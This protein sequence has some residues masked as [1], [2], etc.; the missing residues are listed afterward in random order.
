[1]K[2][3]THIFLVIILA[4][5]MITVGQV[6][7]FSFL[8]FDF[9]AN[10]TW[11]LNQNMYG[12][13]ELNYNLKFGFSGGASYKYFANKFGYSVGLG[14]GSF[15]QRYSGNMV[16]AD[17]KLRINQ[18]YLELPVLGMYK[19]GGNKQQTWISCGPQLMY[20]LSAQ[21][22]FQR[23]NGQLI[24]EPEM[25][26]PGSTDVINRFNIVD[27]MLAVEVTHIYAYKFTNVRPFKSNQKTIWML[28]LKSAIGLTDIN[29]PDFKVSST[30][31]LY[32]GSH[33]FY[34]GVNIGFM[35]NR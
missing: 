34:L 25:L 1:M 22:D 5:P 24:P 17:A 27:I 13:P 16:G 21:Q 14:L 2:K 10:N 19:L 6:N 18:V 23:D 30:R 15:G 7:N 32:A 3:V 4:C 11:I 20:L 9:G 31:N 26:N 28:S 29:S 12:N 8:S 35:F 33:N